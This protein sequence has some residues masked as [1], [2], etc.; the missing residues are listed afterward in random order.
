[1]PILSATGPSIGRMMKAISKKSRKNARKKM[2]M[3]T[4]IRKPVWPPGRFVEQVFD[5]VGAVHA[6]EHEREHAR[7]DQDEH[8][9]GRDA[10]GA[11]HGFLHQ[12]PVEAAVQRRQDQRAHGAHGARFGGRGHR[13]VD[14]RQAA[15]AAQHGEDQDGRRDDA[16][17]ALAPTGPSRSSVRA[18]LG[19]PGTCSRLDAAQQEG[20]ERE[21]QHLQDRRP[22]AP[23]YMSPT[24]LAELVGQ[25]H[26]HERRRHRSA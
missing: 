20:V 10:H 6:L 21:D 14:A 5:P 25:H 7:A 13:G 23:L 24:R 8:H 1:M 17:Q 2:K 19:T 4:T 15:H 12:R 9:H 22:Q 26:Q 11:G 3:L 18:S 16:A